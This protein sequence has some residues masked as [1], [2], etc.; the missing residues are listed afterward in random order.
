MKI[1]KLN[2][3]DSVVKDLKNS[4]FVKGICG[5][6]YNGSESDRE[7]GEGNNNYKEKS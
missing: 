6:L 1:I 7:R 2:M 3:D 5:N 4:L